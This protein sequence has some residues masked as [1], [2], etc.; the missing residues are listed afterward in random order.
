MHFQVGEHPLG[1]KFPEKS[2]VHQAAVKYGSETKF[3]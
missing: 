1:E 3:Y 2:I